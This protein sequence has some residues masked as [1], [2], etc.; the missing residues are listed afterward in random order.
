MRVECLIVHG[1]HLRL[2]IL[3][4]R[5]L[6]AQ[7]LLFVDDAAHNLDLEVWLLLW[8]VLACSPLKLLLLLQSSRQ[9]RLA[10]LQLVCE[11]DL[12]ELRL[13]P[14]SRSRWWYGLVGFIFRNGAFSLSFAFLNAV[15]GALLKKR[16]ARLNREGMQL[17]DFYTIVVIPSLRCLLPPIQIRSRAIKEGGAWIDIG[18]G[19]ALIIEARDGA[20]AACLAEDLAWHLD[21]L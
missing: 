10:P 21:T 16:V 18:A 3:L 1:H 19:L 20:D 15:F 12:C 6:F 5:G 13:L 14:S 11:C 2:H 8:Q 17:Q 4:V 7:L 9:V